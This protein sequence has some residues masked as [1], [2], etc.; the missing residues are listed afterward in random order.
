[1]FGLPSDMP[2]V[3]LNN[4][5]QRPM[6]DRIF[7][8]PFWDCPYNCE[9]CC[10]DSLPGKP[11]E[12]PTSGEAT[13]MALMDALHER[14]GRPIQVHVYGGEPL[15]RPNTIAALA[16]RLVD[17]ASFKKMYLYSTM[18]KS[19]ADRVLAALRDPSLLRVVVNDFTANERVHE[20][21]AELGGGDVAEFYNNLVVFPT[22]RGR[23]GEQAYR[24]SLL[25]RVMPSWAPGR[26]CFAT[27]SGM[28]VNGAHDTVH[29]C[30]LPQSPVVGT[31]EEDARVII[32]RYERKLETFHSEI[33]KVMQER[34]LSHACSACELASNWDTRVRPDT[35]H[36]EGEGQ[37]VRE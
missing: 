32:E 29:L 27:V 1:M 21:M 36:L 7:Y 37:T 19:G 35:S 13:L 34:G 6:L 15:L 23:E 3:A 4:L 16:G 17:R 33:R 22:G 11:P 5:M 18:R 14:T 26:S 9:F 2:K 12:H 25:E 28:L 31:F 8:V 10:V 30:C 20:R 24:K